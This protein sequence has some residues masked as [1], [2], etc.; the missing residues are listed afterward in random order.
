MS[1]AVPLLDLLLDME[2]DIGDLVEESI[3]NGEDINQTNEKGYTV[4]MLSSMGVSPTFARILLE[5][6]A[7]VNEQYYGENGF[8]HGETS[9]HMA[10]IYGSWEIAQELL[11]YGADIEMVDNRGDTPLGVSVANDNI[12]VVKV[13]LKEG[14][15]INHISGG[16]TPLDYAY[17]QSESE[18]VHGDMIIDLL[19][20]KGAKRGPAYE[21][22]ELEKNKAHISQ[23]EADKKLDEV[24]KMIEEYEKGLKPWWKIWQ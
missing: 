2:E 16:F 18:R 10:A 21:K 14:A 11:R 9:L 15:C 1:T 22:E 19:I 4:L 17:M 13:L 3:R 8:A 7:N 6:G 5:H 23:E 12:E 20:S 24:Y